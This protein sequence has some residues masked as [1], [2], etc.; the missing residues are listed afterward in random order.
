M[1]RGDKPIFEVVDDLVLRTLFGDALDRGGAGGGGVSRTG[2]S[3]GERS[4]LM[5][6]FAERREIHRM[7]ARSE[8]RGQ[9]FKV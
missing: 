3:C 8:C 2:D 4:E 5:S 6:I 1:D 9:V 7:S